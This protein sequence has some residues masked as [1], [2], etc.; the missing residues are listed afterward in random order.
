MVNKSSGDILGISIT[1]GLEPVAI[2]ICFPLI[3]SSPTAI[4]ELSINSAFHFIT[5]I[6][7]FSSSNSADSS[8]NIS[9]LLVLAYSS[10]SFILADFLP[11]CIRALEGTQP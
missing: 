8:S 3:V 4:V 11:I 1:R 5:L 7:Y 2:T 6:P 10:A 9:C